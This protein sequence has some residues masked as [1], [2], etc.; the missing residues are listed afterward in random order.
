MDIRKLGVIPRLVA[1]AAILLAAFA[2]S[3][4]TAPPA[5]AALINGQACNQSST[6]IL[7]DG[8]PPGGVQALVAGAGQ[9]HQP[10]DDRRRGYLGQAMQHQWQLLV[11]ALED[12]PRILHDIQ[13]VSVSSAPRSSALPWRQRLRQRV[14]VFY[15]VGVAATKPRF[16][17]L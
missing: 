6:S 13:R 4:G 15:A 12:R 2:H 8:N 5:Q 11:S 7:G 14:A 9:L 10:L 17:Q 16:N 1:M 3:T